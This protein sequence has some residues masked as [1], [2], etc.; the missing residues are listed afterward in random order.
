MFRL[1]NRICMM[2]RDRLPR[3]ILEWDYRCGAKGWLKDLLTVCNETNIPPPTELKFIYDMEPIQVKFLRQCR[4]E[5][6]SATE[7]MTKLDTYREVKDF[8]DIGTLVKA[9][10][11]RNERSLVARLLCGILPLEIE[12]GRF[13]DAKRQTRNCKVCLENKIEDEIHFIFTCKSL[14]KVR[15]TKL[16]PYLRTDRNTRRMCNHEKLKWLLSEQHLKEF[17]KILACLYQAR[18]DIVYSAN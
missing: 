11:P 4:E 13:R 1:Y 8:A 12:T 15:K 18:Q 14:K 5:W 2:S 16:K 9:N 17:G 7:E 10:L 6:K 3:K